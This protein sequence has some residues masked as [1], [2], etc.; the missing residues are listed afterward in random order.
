M[1]SG[2]SQ[3]GKCVANLQT[4]GIVLPFLEERMVFKRP[5]LEKDNPIAPEPYMGPRRRLAWLAQ[6][7][8]ETRLK[9][10]I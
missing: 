6:R 9:R 1:N 7:R 5:E 10:K 8:W 4:Y 2:V 3:V